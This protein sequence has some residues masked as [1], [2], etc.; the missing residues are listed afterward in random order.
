MN[1]KREKKKK[2]QRE[3]IY[4]SDGFVNIYNEGTMRVLERI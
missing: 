2:T 3:S 1:P 4:F